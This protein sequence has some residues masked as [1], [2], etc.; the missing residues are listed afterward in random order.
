V[1]TLLSPQ[2]DP[3]ERVI[4]HNLLLPHPDLVSLQE[5]LDTGTPSGRMFF[6][7]VAIMAQW[8]RAAIANQIR[9]LPDGSRI[10]IRLVE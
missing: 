1:L 6:N 10:E 3:Q 2:Q 4:R 8:E 5:N 7:M 9:D